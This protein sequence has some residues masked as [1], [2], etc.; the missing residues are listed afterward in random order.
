MVGDLDTRTNGKMEMTKDRQ[1]L[2]TKVFNQ[3][4]E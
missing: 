4:W 1:H 2:D 3:L